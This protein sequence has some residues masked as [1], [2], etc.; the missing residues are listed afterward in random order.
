MRTKLYMEYDD[1]DDVLW[2]WLG[3]DELKR[4]QEVGICNGKKEPS[5]TI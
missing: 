5:Q 3:E 2:Q 1:D 4:W